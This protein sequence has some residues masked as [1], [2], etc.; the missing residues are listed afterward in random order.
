LS[1]LATRILRRKR[2]VSS[3]PLLSLATGTL[4]LDLPDTAAN[5][6][7]V[8]RRMR[9]DSVATSDIG[10]RDRVLYTNAGAAKLSGDRSQWHSG[11]RLTDLAGPVGIPSLRI[12]VTRVVRLSPS[13]AA[14]PSGPPT[15]Q[16]VS[17]RVLVM[18]ARCASFSVRT[19]PSCASGF[20]SSAIGARN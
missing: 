13:F 17:R 4:S 15:T 7:A 12:F 14:A 19:T 8:A 20:V 10:R 18:S 3:G 2:Q 5:L 16:L 9:C 11:A 1:C 6:Q